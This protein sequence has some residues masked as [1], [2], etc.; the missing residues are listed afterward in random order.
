[1]QALFR[2]LR[3]SPLDDPALF[4][5]AVAQ[6]L[7]DG[8]EVGLEP[9][10]PQHGSQSSLRSTRG[11]EVG[12]ARLRVLLRSVSLRR[13]KATLGA[14]L[15]PRTAT[16][17]IVPLP[18][19]GGPEGGGGG[20]EREAY[21]ALFGSLRLAFDALAAAGEAEVLGGGRGVSVTIAWE[22]V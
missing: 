8:D 19:G 14:L 20:G 10:S 12:L 16:T 15:P 1:M 4:K 9:V 5:R 7:R 11:D 6:P 22:P 21:G 17:A 18:E 3:V 2:F 13:P